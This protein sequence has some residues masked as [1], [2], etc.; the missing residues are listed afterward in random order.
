MDER[1][2]GYRQGREANLHKLQT[3]EA[4]LQAYKASAS[5]PSPPCTPIATSS[6]YIM[7][8]LEQPII[9]M[10]RQHIEPMFAPSRMKI[11]ALVQ[12]KNQEIVSKVSPKLDLLARLLAS[13]ADK[14]DRQNTPSIGPS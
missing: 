4:A 2:E 10:V 12:D 11:E 6:A 8:S 5:Q 7:S 13:V 1:L 14:L 3:L 9:E